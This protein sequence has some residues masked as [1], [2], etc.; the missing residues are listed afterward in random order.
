MPFVG[1]GFTPSCAGQFTIC[2]L[3]MSATP[4]G[5]VSFAITFALFTLLTMAPNESLTATGGSLIGVM[6]IVIVAVLDTVP[7]TVTV[8]WMLSVPF[9]FAFGVYVMVPLA[10][11]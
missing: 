11:T 9:A 3:T 2:A 7:P 5:S 4:S 1:V 6:L 10:F 8:Y